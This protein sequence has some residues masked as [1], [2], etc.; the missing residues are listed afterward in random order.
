MNTGIYFHISRSSLCK[1]L[2]EALERVDNVKVLR[3][4][5]ELLDLVP[6]NDGDIEAHVQ[7]TSKKGK[8]PRKT[9]TTTYALQLVIGADGIH[10]RVRDILSS[11]SSLSS[12]SNEFSGWKRPPE[13]FRV[14]RWKSPAYGIRVK[15]LRISQGAL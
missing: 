14:K 2:V 13:A 4:G 11:P 1:I 6:V 10:S 7:T 12:S 9:T 8:N 5:A 3:W 15:T